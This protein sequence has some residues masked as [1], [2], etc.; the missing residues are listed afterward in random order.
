M[1]RDSAKQIEEASLNAWP[2]LRRMVVDGWLVRFSEGYTRRANSVNPLYGGYIDVEEKIRFFEQLYVERK[3]PCV[4]KVTPFVQ[5]NSL[6]TILDT[7][8]YQP[9]APTSVQ[10]LDLATYIPKM[11]ASSLSHWPNPTDLWV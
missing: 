6:D 3:L 11:P 9:E 8:G 4:F 10:I 2:A 7:L 5:P 1:M